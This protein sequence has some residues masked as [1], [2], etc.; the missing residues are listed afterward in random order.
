MDEIILETKFR[1]KKGNNFFFV[2]QGS[3]L[4]KWV[5]QKIMN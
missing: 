3:I 5:Q 2:K 4:I 1:E